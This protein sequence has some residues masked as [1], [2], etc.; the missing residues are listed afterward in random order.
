[1]GK[2][3]KWTIARTVMFGFA[4]VNQVLTMTGR[5]PLPFTCNQFGELVIG[6]FTICAFIIAWWKNNSFTEAAVEADKTFK[7]IEKE[8]EE[9]E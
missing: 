8:I 3:T 4:L 1:M 2:P 9:Y 5:N 7:K 6:V